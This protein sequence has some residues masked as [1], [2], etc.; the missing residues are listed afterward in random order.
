M[1]RSGG[2]VHNRTSAFVRI[3]GFTRTLSALKALG[4]T[5]VLIPLL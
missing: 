2:A 4:G 3:V 5:D 1:V